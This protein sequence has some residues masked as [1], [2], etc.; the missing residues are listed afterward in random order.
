MT[1]N[2]DSR[3][4]QSVVETVLML[5][6]LLVLLAGGY[7]SYRQLSLSGS[8]ESAAHAHL[9]RTGRNLPSIGSR[10]ARTIHPSDNAVRFNVRNGPLAEQFPLFRGMAGRTVA[11]V[12]VSCPKDPVGGFIDLPRHDARRNAEGSVDCWG[13]GTRSGSTIRRTVS[14]ILLTGALR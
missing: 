1:R 6:L 4:G 8:T 5:P 14:G 12:E 11:S 13:K 10:L 2:S 9:L 3:R 7:W